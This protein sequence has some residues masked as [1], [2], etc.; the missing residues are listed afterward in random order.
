MCHL[1]LYIKKYTIV[2]QMYT[3]MVGRVKLSY[4]EIQ[5]ARYN[6]QSIVVYLCYDLWDFMTSHLIYKQLIYDQGL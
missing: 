6:R 3:E 4:P 1:I 5:Q 2:C